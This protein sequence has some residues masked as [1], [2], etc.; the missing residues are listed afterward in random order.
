M[1]I[2]IT[3]TDRVFSS[4]MFFDVK[5]ISGV[6]DLV[7]EKPVYDSY[8]EYWTFKSI[9]FYD[10][11]GNVKTVGNDVE[12]NVAKLID[13][14]LQADEECMSHMHVPCFDFDEMSNYEFY[15]QKL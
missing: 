2:E 10:S 15:K 13:E 12:S 3:L 1:A 8:A 7:V 11:D 6:N 5:G 4:E 14:V 9:T